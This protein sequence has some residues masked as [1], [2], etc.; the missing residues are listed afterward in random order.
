MSQD[1]HFNTQPEHDA[2]EIDRINNDFYSR[3]NY[4]WVPLYLPSYSD[5]R[6]W[7]NALNQDLGYWSHE[8]LP[9]DLSIWVGGCGTNQ[10]ILTA[11][12]F[13]AARVVGSDVS[14]ESLNTCARI[15]D[16]LGV[17]NLTLREESLN[18][19]NYEEAFDYVICTGVIHHNAD[20]ALPLRNLKRALK[21][22]GVLELMVYNYY[23]RI[24][25]TAFQK[26]IRL[27]G[28]QGNRPNIDT[29]LPL[30]LELIGSFPKPCQMQDFLYQQRTLPEAAVADSLLQPVEYSYTPHSLNQLA[31]DCGLHLLTYCLNQF[32]K[33]SGNTDWWM[34]FETPEQQA[35]YQQLDDLDRW[36]VTNLL[37]GEQSPML[38]FY[39]QREDAP[40]AVKTNSTLNQGFLDT[41][42]V[43]ARTQVRN[44]VLKEAGRY[45]AAAQTLPYPAPVTPVD[46]LAAQVFAQC[47][48]SRPIRDII[49]GLG[50]Q[51]HPGQV[52]ALRLAL[53]TSGYPYLQAVAI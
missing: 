14:T 41:C 18:E 15:A 12:K 53:C 43:P 30:T 13:P 6:F 26:A 17:T 36:Q 48:G 52:D 2:A 16:Q 25:T 49:A 5:S 32:D 31:N 21:P 22:R 47:D 3:F 40:E 39:L 45:Q 29:E 19:V 1:I 9:E 7:S 44:H 27:L 37:L 10:A 24:Q 38:W 42:F 8:R 23:H 20:P 34:P 28:G 4:P 51:L 46:P 11:L 35:A 33:A 50:R